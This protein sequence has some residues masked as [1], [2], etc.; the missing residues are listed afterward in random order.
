MSGRSST[1]PEWFAAMCSHVPNRGE[2]MVRYYSWYSKQYR[3]QQNE[4]NI[5]FRVKIFNSLG[6]H[7]YLLAVGVG[8]LFVER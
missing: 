3:G 4:N 5:S 6:I 8:R 1:A 2:Q 7:Q